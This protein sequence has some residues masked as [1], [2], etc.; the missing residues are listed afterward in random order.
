[1]HIWIYQIL[2]ILS[3][4]NKHLDCFQ[5]GVLQVILLK[6]FTQKSLHGQVFPY[7]IYLCMP[8]WLHWIFVAV[9]RFSLVAASDGFSHCG[10]QALE[11]KS[12]NNFG[13]EAKLPCGMQDLPRPG[14][15][16]MSPIL[17]GR[18]FTTRP[19]GK[20]RFS[21]H[22]SWVGLGGELLGCVVTLCFNV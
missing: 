2:F 8:F 14:T 17:A 9:H 11:C 3:P 22:F 20:S 12:F 6:K 7:F 5:F 19:L 16:P 10:T 15:Q 18:F 13:V 4:G 21:L 1:M